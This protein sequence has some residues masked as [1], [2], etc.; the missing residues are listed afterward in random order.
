ML[1]RG[2]TKWRCYLGVSHQFR[3][4]FHIAL[5]SLFWQCCMFWSWDIG[6]RF[7]GLNFRLVV[8]GVLQRSG[9]PLSEVSALATPVALLL[10]SRKTPIGTRCVTLCHISFRCPI[11]ISV[12]F[13]AN[14][15][16]PS[17]MEDGREY[18]VD[19]VPAWEL[20]GGACEGTLN[21]ALAVCRSAFVTPVTSLQ[22]FIWGKG[23]SQ[24]SRPWGLVAQSSVSLFYFLSL[25]FINLLPHLL[26]A[27]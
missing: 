19:S 8:K 5:R 16:A 11:S 13:L 26:S 23:S 15:P 25:Y 2:G 20:G 4:C 24:R 10:L 12:S 21:P 1:V 27:D 22:P 6:L 14:P 17:R 3:V 9:L 7:P 18:S